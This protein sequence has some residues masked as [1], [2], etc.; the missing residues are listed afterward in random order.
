MA[1]CRIHTSR[2]NAFVRVEVLPKTEG[3]KGILA[4][5]RL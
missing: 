5:K 1:A 2:N 3:R 4:L